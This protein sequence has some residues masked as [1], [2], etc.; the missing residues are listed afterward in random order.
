MLALLRSR[1]RLLPDL[2]LALAVAVVVLGP[3]LLSR[4]FVLVGDMVFVPDQPWKDAWT[5]GDGGVPRA[6]PSDA[7]VSLLD[8]VIGGELLQALVLLGTFVAAG[9]G[10]ARLLGDLSFAA[11]AAGAVCFV[12][13]PYV[14]ER[15]AIG[16][17]ALLCGYAALPWVAHAVVRLRRGEGRA[18]VPLLV[19]LAVAAWSSPTGGVLTVLTA[20]VLTLPHG[21][22]AARVVAAG[23]L[24]NLPWLV[25]AFGNG[26][27]QLAP[28]PFGVAAF[29]SGADTPLGVLG[30][31]LT[32]GGIWKESIVPAARGDWFVLAG[33]LV[34][35]GA[36]VGLWRGR[37]RAVLPLAPALG[38]S[39]GVLALAA[40]GAY[41]VTRPVAEWLVVH[42]PGG[43]LVRDGQKWI[44]PWVLVAATGFALVVQEVAD[45]LRR[46]GVEARAWVVA[47]VLLPV[48][49]LPTFAVGLGGF[50]ASDEYPQEWYEL[51]DE[52]ERLGVADDAVV[53]LPFS[54]YRRFDWTP[55]TVLDPA[56]RFFPGRFVLEDAL[57]VPGGVVGG[58]S[59]LASRVR[60]AGSSEELAAVLSDGGV[61][62]ALVHRSSDPGPVPDG[63]VEVVPGHQVSL[64]RLAEPTGESAAV[65]GWRPVGY[66][67]LDLLVLAVTLVVTV[68][69]V[70]RSNASHPGATPA[71]TDADEA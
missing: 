7:V 31:L 62:W 15:L 66:A 52:M 30:S 49:A 67:V 54:T 51:R 56:P 24:V 59:Q 21:R 2:L 48:V 41:G 37:R 10:V 35:L 4:G 38:L 29:A 68:N 32:F 55:R 43:G 28:D 39:V 11:R 70:H 44:A 50:L 45:A 57:A 47:L 5:G 8:S 23:L 36:C 26:A 63:A 9:L 33:V 27:D 46:R 65:P 3:V 58:E 64:W 34:V 69:V 53:A 18:W 19:A 71:Y 12:W 17:W 42:V 61:R 25:P 60:A 16:H 6:V 14:H 20:T 22:L 40:L 13:N 1:P